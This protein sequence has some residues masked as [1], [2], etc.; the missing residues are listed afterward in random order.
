[1][2]A[3]EVWR[4]EQRQMKAEEIEEKKEYGT[5]VYWDDKYTNDAS[6]SFDWYQRYDGLRGIILE[7]T[8]HESKVLNVGCGNSPLSEA[9]CCD[10]EGMEITNI[11]ISR[12]CIG[13][14]KERYEHVE[15]LTWYTMD[16]L[17]P[18]SSLL[19][20]MQHRIH[21]EAFDFIFAKATMDAISCGAGANKNIAIMCS[22][23][24][25]LL[26][27]GGKCM[28]VS[29]EPPEKQLARLEQ[30]NYQWEVAVQAVARP[31]ASMG[32]HDLADVEA[33]DREKVHWVYIMT[34]HK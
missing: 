24:S 7:H 19:F 13:N 17:A 30:S 5:V 22:Q 23:M 2:A 6:E 34:K 26:K 28:V 8:T 29:F 10:Q 11:D 14:M 3:N 31:C 18:L 12:K 27:I 1:M 33:V 16:I 4:D 32:S 9:M 15:C 25:R 21:D 20:E